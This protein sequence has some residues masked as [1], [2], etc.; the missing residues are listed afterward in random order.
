MFSATLPRSV[1]I[2][3]QKYMNEYIFL[4]VGQVGSANRDVKQRFLLMEKER[5]RYMLIK[6]L[7]ERGKA[8]VLLKISPFPCVTNLRDD[9]Y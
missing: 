9:A 3:A 6:V 7:R 2:L 8:V 4:A 1:Q 5:K